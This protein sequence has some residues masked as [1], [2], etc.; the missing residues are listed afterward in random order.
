MKEKEVVN[1]RLICIGCD[2]E[3]QMKWVKKIADTNPIFNQNKLSF[4]IISSQ[5]RVEIDT[6]NFKRLEECAKKLTA[7]KGRSAVSTDK[8]YIYIK[9]I[10]GNEKLIGI[11]T[12]NRIKNFVPINSK[13][14]LE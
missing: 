5:S 14:V 9:E 8:S 3:Y 13:K 11:L 12:H 2:D 10:D 1:T 7:P 4:V 6:L